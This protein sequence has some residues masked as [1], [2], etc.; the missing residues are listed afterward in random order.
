M[1]S[2]VFLLCFLLGAASAVC[3]LHGIVAIVAIVV[4]G[5]AIFFAG[6]QFNRPTSG[7]RPVEPVLSDPTPADA[8]KAEARKSRELEM[9]VE[10]LEEELRGSEARGRLSKKDWDGEKARY[11]E[12]LRLMSDRVKSLDRNFKGAMRAKDQ[13]MSECHKWRRDFES[14]E[15]LRQQQAHEIPVR[16]ITGRPRWAPAKSCG[17]GKRRRGRSGKDLTAVAK[18]ALVN[19]EW[20]V[21]M[22]GIK[23]EA[24]SHV[25]L[26]DHHI[27]ALTS[28]VTSLSQKTERLCE[29]PRNTV[30]NSNM[31]TQQD[32]LDA[33]NR[34][35]RVA[36]EEHMR[37]VSELQQTHL[38]ELAA[39]END[40]KEKQG[41][42]ESRLK[43]KVAELS[44][45]QEQVQLGQGKANLML[46]QLRQLNAELTE[47]L[48]V[49]S[50]ALLQRRTESETLVQK[51]L[52]LH[53]R[54]KRDRKRITKL[55]R[56]LRESNQMKDIAEEAMGGMNDVINGLEEQIEGLKEEL[57]DARWENPDPED[58]ETIRTPTLEAQT[59][60]LVG[61]IGDFTLGGSTSV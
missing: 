57:E 58:L 13:A 33:E 43:A 47:K 52:K 53:Q 34:I 29:E 36:K 24:R 56:D 59:D 51:I 11:D 14:L 23:D 19:A 15:S 9:K 3:Y 22:A 16:R 18:V 20:E 44:G 1:F 27:E 6:T 4:A 49:E 25:A 5:A 46:G 21:K 10:A 8:Y 61:A 12:K 60:D 7:L 32:V 26:L 38:R 50:E 55:Q 17:V 45:Q 28:Q 39:A 37:I 31:R 2:L 48:R 30:D 35:I 42:M 54:K 41:M 40:H